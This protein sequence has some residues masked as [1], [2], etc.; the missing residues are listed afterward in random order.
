VIVA[1]NRAVAH[2]L[3]DV[4]DRRA[5]TSSVSSSRQLKSWHIH[6]STTYLLSDDVFESTLGIEPYE[7]EGKA[8]MGML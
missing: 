5:S 7:G 8:F 3:P 1:T 6:S 4:V 2:Y